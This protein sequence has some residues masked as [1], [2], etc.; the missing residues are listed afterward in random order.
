MTFENPKLDAFPQKRY[1]R[2]RILYGR[3]I[4]MQINKPWIIFAVAALLSAPALSPITAQARDVDG[5][6]VSKNVSTSELKPG[7]EYHAQ[8]EFEVKQNE[9]HHHGD[10][11]DAENPTTPETHKPKSSKAE[12]LAKLKLKRARQAAK[13]RLEKRA[14]QKRAHQRLKKEIIIW[15]VSFI[16]MAVI[17]D[18]IF[19]LPIRKG[20]R[21]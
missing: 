20:P 9:L 2:G 13:R 21:K 4:T 14:A 18:Q 10:S 11:K 15:A 7:G 5:V 17:V 3:R 12:H 19:H 1:F 6:Q 8:F 16:V